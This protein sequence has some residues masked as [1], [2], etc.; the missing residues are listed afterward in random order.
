[1]QLSACG[2]FYEV[3]PVTVKTSESAMSAKFRGLNYKTCCSVKLPT[4][5]LSLRYRGVIPIGFMF[6]TYFLLLP[7]Y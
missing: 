1:M 3:I 5:Q 2:I 4:P 6:D 7:P